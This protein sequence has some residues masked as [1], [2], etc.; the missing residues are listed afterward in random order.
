TRRRETLGLLAIAE[1]DTE[2]DEEETMDRGTRGPA[3]DDEHRKQKGDDY[4]IRD[5][6]QSQNDLYQTT[7]WIKFLVPWGVGVLLLVLWQFYCTLLCVAG[8]KIYDALV[9]IPK[10]L[11]RRHLEVFNN[12]NRKHPHL[13]ADGGDQSDQ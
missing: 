8:T 13:G 9:W 10:K 12:D 3:G 2:K 4:K 7:E 11:D 5:W 6:I 1:A